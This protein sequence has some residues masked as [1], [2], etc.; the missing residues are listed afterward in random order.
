MSKKIISLLLCLCMVLSS[1]II[2]GAADFDETEIKEESVPA[3]ETPVPAEESPAPAEESPAPAESQEEPPAQAPEAAGQET[4]EQPAQESKIPA[5]FKE[6]LLEVCVDDSVVVQVGGY[7]PEGARLEVKPLSD[8]AMAYVRSLAAPVEGEGAFYFAYDIKLVVGEGEARTE[9]SPADL[10]VQVIFYFK[11]Q[12]LCFGGDTAV[13]HVTAS[14]DKLP[15]EPEETEETGETAAETEEA[16]ESE[17]I[18]EAAPCVRVDAVYNS[19]DYILFNAA[20]LN[21]YAITGTAAQRSEQPA[22]EETA[23]KKEL[24]L[25]E[26]GVTVAGELPEG[27]E[28]N[29]TPMAD[30][31][32]SAQSSAPRKAAARV[33]VQSAGE[34]TSEKQTY[35]YDVKL[36][37]DG[38]EI[39]PD[40]TVRV[41]FKDVAVFENGYVEVYHILD[42]ADAILAGKGVEFDD[43]DFVAAFP[44]EAA[45]AAELTGKTGVVYV[46]C[47]STEAGTVGYDENGYVCVD[48]T[49]FSTYYIVSGNSANGTTVADVIYINDGES[50][51]YYVAP[52]TTLRMIRGKEDD[53]KANWVWAK[54]GTNTIS[55]ISVTT[56]NG[57]KSVGKDYP[58]GHRTNPII[59]K[60]P[61]NA[62]PGTRY[63]L[64]TRRDVWPGY[65]EVKTT[66][67]VQSEKDVISNTINNK[68]YGLYLAVLYDSRQ[69]PGEPCLA[70]PS[71]GYGF[72]TGPAY[73][74]SGSATFANSANGYVIPEVVN[75]P[76]M[77]NSADGT[78]T[79]GIV[80]TTGERTKAV[81]RN[82]SW[83]T[84]LQKIA[85]KGNFKATDGKTVTTANKDSYEILPYTVKLQT[86]FSLGWHVDCY[87]VPKANVTLSYNANF[88]DGVTANMFALP[89][90]VAGV[91]TFNATVG[92][93]RVGS[94]DIK[95][96]T[97][98][99][100]SYQGSDYHAKFEGW[101]TRSDGRGTMYQ[102]GS[103]ISVSSDTVLYAQWSYDITL[104]SGYLE[105]YKRVVTAPGSKAAPTGTEFTMSVKF[106]KSGN[107]SGKLYNHDGTYKG[108]VNSSSFKLKDGQY[109]RFSVP[110]DETFTV[111]E[112]SIPAG[113]TAMYDGNGAKIVDGATSTVTVTN[114]YNVS[115]KVS[116]TVT[117]ML[118]NLSGFYEADPSVDSLSGVAGQP[119]EAKARYYPGFTAKPFN[120][121]II[122]NGL[123][124]EIYY[125][126]NTHSVAYSYTGSVHPA[127]EPALPAAATYKYG[128]DVSVAAVPSAVGY[129]FDGWKISG[130]TASNGKF[131]MPDNDVTLTGSW[132]AKT[133]VGYTV[134]YVE[135]GTT[136][137]IAAS[138]TVTGRT[139]GTTVRESAVDVPGFTA[140]AP[141]AQDVVLDAYNKVVTFYYTRNTYE[142]VINHLE[143]R[144]VGSGV[145]LKTVRA[146]ARFGDKITVAA[147]S[148]P[149]FTYKSQD[150][151]EIVIGVSGN[152]ANVYYT[153]NSYRADAALA[154]SDEGF[155]STS[156]SGVYE[157]EQQVS[158]SAQLKPG[159]NF[160]GWFDGDSADANKLSD[161]IDYGF[162]MPSRDVKYYARSV[163]QTVSYSYEAVCVD[164]VPA[165]AVFGTVA[166][167]AE[168]V[169]KATGTP[170]ST[171]AAG[172]DFTFIG[173]FDAED[174]LV[175]TDPAYSPNNR[176]SDG[177][178]MG[179]TFYAKF[180]YA[181]ADYTVKHMVERLD[182][183]GNDEKET[184]T[185]LSGKIG[186]LTEAAAKDYEGFTP[187]T[188]IEQK[189][190]AKDDSDTVEIYYTRN[191]YTITYNVVNDDPSAD[192]TVTYKYGA[193]VEDYLP[194]QQYFTFK[195]WYTFEDD[196][197]VK[198]DTMPAGN[199]IVYGWFERQ[200]ASLT[201]SKGG[202][203]AGENAIFVI[204]GEGIEGGLR[205]K[206]P[207]GGSVTVNGLCVGATYTVTEESWSYKY[208]TQSFSVD[209]TEE[210]KVYE[211]PVQ[212]TL[213]GDHPWLSGETS[214]R[215]VFDPAE[216]KPVIS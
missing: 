34:E 207:N 130:A 6:Q 126:R 150:K 153:R 197:W 30:P 171:A 101:N 108:D 1:V 135:Q 93:A 187:V 59:V 44:D 98:I 109:A 144:L 21:V 186:S 72:F 179:G 117:H 57:S 114:T 40:G 183:S 129:T 160:V 31:F 28:L 81:V 56:N 111:T 42:S 74:I 196:D 163:E 49:S 75:N 73:G 104:G 100:V 201:I 132:T 208:G 116:Y 157:Y 16:D 121:L 32:A 168:T 147:E 212:N 118:E 58:S 203:Q 70:S 84:M 210:G 145:T 80:D 29:V 68:Q 211:A 87:I 169:G 5:G 102:P 110:K 54:H 180:E 22:A 181:E 82:I 90:P 36:S 79:V 12:G 164:T 122:K 158:F 3:A 146:S 159:Y 76:N 190:V 52:G 61:A 64:Y 45:L 41:S 165:G 35:T 51:T 170:K 71:S 193:P 97:T 140:V 151:Q 185:G 14:L 216:W 194:E 37:L 198:P 25:S 138:K 17:K 2:T 85:E 199:I 94:T 156:G 38:Q 39:Q 65:H 182:G 175:S 148:F 155:T 213:D 141:V 9:F 161:S 106:S 200:V 113:F 189:T 67:I 89:S 137:E 8:E 7:M 127:N 176:D 15:V 23:E 136:T 184:E 83:D 206:V 123:N 77:K 191:E 177:L 120:Q 78:N 142:Y 178:L 204:T 149:G 215:N 11:E 27:A 96:G 99:T 103:T 105:I 55:G 174:K 112:N 53:D 69:L 10:G 195:G 13:Y 139:F 86:A 152:E 202:M 188:P 209:V 91:P 166:P 24:A 124:V 48:T 134:K 115:D 162:S 47:F 33:A 63:E 133:D 46:E 214:K 26:G 128:A 88:A 20:E 92:T 125:T 50:N 18:E 172:E 131:S 43:P 107:I 66:F 60:I 19:G 4:G 173:W 167:A 205:V 192:R 95:N 62:T 154:A 119:T 143:Y